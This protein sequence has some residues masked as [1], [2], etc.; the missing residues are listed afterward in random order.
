[1]KYVPEGEEGDERSYKI[2]EKGVKDAGKVE[3]RGKNHVIDD[4]DIVLF[5]S[6]AGKG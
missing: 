5:K 2:A 1:M 3:T 4:G 6:G